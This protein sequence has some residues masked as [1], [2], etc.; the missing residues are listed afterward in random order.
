MESYRKVA[1]VLNQIVRASSVVECMNSI[2]RMHQ[3][4]HRTVTQ[5]MLDVKRLVLE[6]SPF[7][8]EGSEKTAVRTNILG[9]RG[10]E[11]MSSRT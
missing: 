1:G 8:Q 6:R 9:S 4:R 5:A 10:R 7:P 3:T 2:I 11:A